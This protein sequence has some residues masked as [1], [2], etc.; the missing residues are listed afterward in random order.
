MVDHCCVEQYDLLDMRQR[1]SYLLNEL[2]KLE[3]TVEAEAS[4]HS[5]QFVYDSICLAALHVGNAFGMMGGG[6]IG[7]LL[8]AEPCHDLSPEAL[9]QLRRSPSFKR[10]GA[11][12]NELCEL[13]EQTRPVV[14][15]RY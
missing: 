6:Y 3:S 11:V 15:A 12:F 13:A 2:P 7:E 1:L 14:K 8:T 9:E 5:V 10:L 4:G